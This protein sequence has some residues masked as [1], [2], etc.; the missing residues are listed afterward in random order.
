M[1]HSCPGRSCEEIFSGL[2]SYTGFSSLWLVPMG[3]RRH[4]LFKMSW[5]GLT[6][7]APSR[8]RCKNRTYKMFKELAAS[9]RITEL[10][11]REGGGG[12]GELGQKSPQ[13]QFGFIIR[14]KNKKTGN[15]R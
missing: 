9:K 13:G 6:R 7:Q 1:V 3:S 5:K 12:G 11:I 8:S 14:K 15:S 2:L 4:K 10:K